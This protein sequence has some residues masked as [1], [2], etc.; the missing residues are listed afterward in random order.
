MAGEPNCLEVKTVGGEGE[1][2]LDS[3]T[4]QTSRRKKALKYGCVSQQA[5][6]EKV[7]KW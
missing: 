2:S 6:K 1:G 7:Q 5:P 4:K 3:G